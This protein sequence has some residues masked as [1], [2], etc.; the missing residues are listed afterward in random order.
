MGSMNA[1]SEY[2]CMESN[3][4]ERVRRQGYEPHRVGQG[5]TVYQKV[6]GG[7]I[8]SFDT[9]AKLKWWVE[10]IEWECAYHAETGD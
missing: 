8:C 4:F 5:Y 2:N 7:E 1:G 10:H 9:L 3:V 6:L